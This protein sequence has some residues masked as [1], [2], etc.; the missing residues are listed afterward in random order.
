MTVNSKKVE[1]LASTASEVETK[2]NTLLNVMHTATIVS[3]KTVENYLSTGN[4]ISSMINDVSQINDISS[5]NAR[6]VEEIA[7]AAEHLNKM[8]EILNLKLSEF[9]T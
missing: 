6:S 4:D 7:G 9:R 3:D 8:T 5:E 1:S 2:I